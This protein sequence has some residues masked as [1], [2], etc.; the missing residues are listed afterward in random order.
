[1]LSIFNRKTKDMV[2]GLSKLEAFNAVE[3]FP[4]SIIVRNKEDSLINIALRKRN[5]NA[6]DNSI[7]WTE[8]RQFSKDFNSIP[9]EERANRIVLFD[10]ETTD[11]YNAYA[12]SI[13]IIVYNIREDKVEE[14]F[15]TLINPLDV[16]NPEAIEVHKITPEMVMDEKPF[17]EYVEKINALFEGAD[18]L[19]GQNLEFDLKV[20][21]R[22]YE[23][24]GLINPL[25]GCEVFD[26][27]HMAKEV[28]QAV[29]V[30]G[31]IKNPQLKESCEYF[32]IKFD[33]AD[34]FHNALV[35]TK[36]CLEIFKCLLRYH[37]N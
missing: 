31:K 26:T 6:F 27:M 18:F 24:L 8:L 15:Y 3:N 30:K 29:D 20:I 14:E 13:A 4:D 5:L 21:E 10:T 1:M 12:V 37:V 17:S 16:I 2:K 7:A 9:E 32:G 28:V 35:D 36:A 11:K 25:L 33:D 22:E 23:R 34:E 19:V